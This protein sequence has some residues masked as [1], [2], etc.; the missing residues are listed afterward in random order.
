METGFLVFAETAIR[1]VDERFGR[2][3][4]WL[5]AIVVTV[6]VPIGLVI[7]AFIVLS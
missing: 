3:A 5:V 6:F 1:Y 2:V 4:A 7:A